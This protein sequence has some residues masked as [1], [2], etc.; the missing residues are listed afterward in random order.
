[1]FDAVFI[2]ADNTL[3]DFD[4]TEEKALLDTAHKFSVD[5]NE[6]NL[7]E[8]KAINKTCWELHDNGKLANADLNLRRWSLWLERIH[9]TAG[10]SA[11]ELANYYADSLSRQ[12]EKEE[13]AEK[14]MQYLI[15]K[16]PVHIITNGF[17]SSQL[18]RWRLAGWESLL[19][20]ITVSAVVGVQKPD[21]E[22]FHIAMKEVGISDA[23]RCLMIGDNITADVQGPQAV[24]MK[25][26][27]YQRNGAENKTN[28]QPDF[29]VTHLNEI[30]KIF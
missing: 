21:A 12:C 2:D 18:H 22:I 14:L 30:E 19:Q 1:M 29:T 4:R 8:Y 3:F 5:F 23:S 24:G 7:S 9:P 6:Q 11:I 13:G 10:I 26:C 28:I 27:W 15:A 16:A 25:G 20:G 17:P